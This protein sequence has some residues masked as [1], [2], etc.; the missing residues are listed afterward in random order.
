MTFSSHAL[1]RYKK[2]FGKKT[3]SKTRLLNQLHRDFK[4]GVKERKPSG[5]PGYYILVLSKYQAVCSRHHVVTI[6]DLDFDPAQLPDDILLGEA[7]D[8][9]PM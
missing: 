3:T 6:T 4:Y 8:V 9:A 1:R 5:V 2:R 7:E